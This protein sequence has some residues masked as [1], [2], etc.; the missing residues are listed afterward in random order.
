MVTGHSIH[1]QARCW[2]GRLAARGTTVCDWHGARRVEVQLASDTRRLDER[3]EAYRRWLAELEVRW[4]QLNGSPAS[5]R[6]LVAE[7]REAE[8]AEWVER[9][10]A[11][12]WAE[13]P[14]DVRGRHGGAPH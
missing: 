4:V 1:R 10:E 12:W 5:L 13:L 3:L 8:A 7:G 6:R 11:G 14:A 9:V 2:C